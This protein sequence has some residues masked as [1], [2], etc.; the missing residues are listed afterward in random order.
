[1]Q[2]IKTDKGG[3]KKRGR[4]RRKKKNS[5]KFVK[6]MAPASGKQEIKDKLKTKK[7][8]T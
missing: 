2:G 3:M 5:V 6:K 4:W 1:M 7:K 8:P